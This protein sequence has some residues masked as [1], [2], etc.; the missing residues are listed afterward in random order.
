MNLELLD[1]ISYHDAEI[2]NYMRDGNNISFQ[3][4]DGWNEEDYYKIE[5]KNI[6]VQVMNNKP[7]LICYLLEVFNNINKYD[8][9]NL[10][11][12]EF[13]RLEEIQNER[14]YYLKLWIRH[15]SDLGIKVDITMDKYQFD[16][17]DVSLCNDY[18]DTG[19]LYIKFLF[20]DINIT[21]YDLL[22]KYSRTSLENM[23][24]LFKYK[25]FFGEKEFKF[26]SIMS[27]GKYL[28]SELKCENN[29]I[30]IKYSNILD[31][32]DNIVLK[33]IG[34]LDEISKKDLNDFNNYIEGKNAYC[35][36]C[37]RI[38][39]CSKN[40]YVVGFLVSKEKEIIFTCNNIVYEGKLLSFRSIFD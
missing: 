19:R 18:D 34:V 28:F 3:L 14:K 31:L 10:Y 2:S 35:C 36:N 26:F 27:L 24:N 32:S 8:A 38:I 33:F 39:E 21:K 25:E 13:G 22:D 20:E 11:S 5:L 40:K 12:G 9:L 4:H 30:F 7:E 15:P 23:N 6:K 1:K 29:N 37:I 16:C 17:L